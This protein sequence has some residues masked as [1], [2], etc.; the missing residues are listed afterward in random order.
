M[1]ETAE[2]GTEIGH[3]SGHTKVFPPLN[4]DYFSPQLIWLALTFAVLYLLLSR[5]A[6]PRIGEVIEERRD[7]IKRDLDAAERL[8][9]ET[10]AAL[11][12]YEKALA[13]ARGNANSIAK[14]TRGRLAGEVDQERARVEGQIGAKIAEAETRID[15]MKSKALASVNEIAAETAAA[16]VAK[17]LGQEASPD[18]VRRAL[19]PLAGK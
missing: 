14:E 2:V 4:P 10:E 7:R 12:G 18:E 16:V 5:V 11:A 6:L 1:A 3:E 9:G 15:G 8:K 13:D 19:Q 17:L